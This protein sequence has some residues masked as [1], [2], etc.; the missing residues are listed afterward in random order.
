MTSEKTYMVLPP[1]IDGQFYK[2]FVDWLSKM[3]DMGEKNPYIVC[4]GNGGDLTFA[5]AICDLIKFH[6]NITGFLVGQANSCHCDIFMACN[7]RYFTQSAGLGFHL[8]KH[9][10]DGYADLTEIQ[11]VLGEAHQYDSR[12]Y[13]IFADASS[14]DREWWREFITKAGGHGCKSVG[15]SFLT[16]YKIAKPIEECEKFIPFGKYPL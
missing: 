8:S 7:E 10:I 3:R 9:Y 16:S 14:N 5:L 13:K 15:T 6:G 2:E 4:T 1:S 11:N 12:L